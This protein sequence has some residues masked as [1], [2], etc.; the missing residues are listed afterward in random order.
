MHADNPAGAPVD[1]EGAFALPADELRALA[2]RAVDDFCDQLA[3]L[4]DEPVWRPVPPDVRARLR[5]PLPREGRGLA[6]TY[7][8]FRR[9]VLPYRYGNVHPR[10]WGWVNGSGLPAAVLA[11]FLAASMNSNAGAF[12]QS[13]IHV[14]EQVLAWLRELLQL[15]AEGDGLLTS[16]G[17][18]ANLLGLAAARHAHAPDVRARGLGEE[19]RLVLYASSETHSSVHKAVELL[20][21]GL[22][23][24]RLLPVDG[25]YRVRLDAL[26]DA[27][28]ADRAAGLAPFALVANAGTV[29]TGATDPLAELVSLARRENLWLH[30]DGAF[31][32]LAWLCPE[33]RAELRG[34]TEVDS[35]AFDLHK[36]MYLP[37][38]IGCVLV[39]RARGLAAAFTT[40]AP[41]LA[42]LRGGLSANT[43]GAFKDRGIELTRRFR[44]LKAWFA[45]NVH[46]ADAFEQA[47]RVNLEQARHLAA[48]VEREPRLELCAPVPLNVV[49]FRYRGSGLDE[50]A[51]DALNR[52]LVVRLQESGVA[53]P[54]QTVVAG[55]FAL[56]V[57]ITNHRTTGADL[58]L[59]VAEVL[60]LGAA[61]E[62][63]PAVRARPTDVPAPS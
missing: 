57:A 53:V 33:R 44:A 13:A 4:R 22:A 28:R 51:L 56:R 39:R 48:R 12:D 63:E 62:R 1:A 20:G 42:H 32:A 40:R 43:D 35:L 54:S 17:S 25:S 11:D 16:G 2:H 41:Y 31:G 36:W 46:G 6:A 45:L 3:D 27:L 9:D 34:L 19:K 10:F 8:A 55:R 58:D 24:L 37:S 14:E 26:E 50:A 5:A 29:N 7:E 59:L 61:L 15:P 23:S 49:C 60:G 38:D 30:V 52:E 18:M 47:I 21:L